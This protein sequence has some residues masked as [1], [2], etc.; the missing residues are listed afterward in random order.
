MKYLEWSYQNDAIPPWWRGYERS[1]EKITGKIISFLQR[2]FLL[3]SL[4]L[5]KRLLNC[6]SFCNSFPLS[7]PLQVCLSMCD[8]FVTTRHYSININ[9]HIFGSVFVWSNRYFS[10]LFPRIWYDSYKDNITLI[11]TVKIRCTNKQFASDWQSRIALS[12]KFRPPLA[13]IDQY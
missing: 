1:L 11:P 9:S 3:I 5:K 13:K 4:N 8:L 2:C 6:D 10:H 7:F 12:A